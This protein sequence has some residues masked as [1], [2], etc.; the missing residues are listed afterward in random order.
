ME[1]KKRSHA[2]TKFFLILSRNSKLKQK[3][4]KEGR[5]KNQKGFEICFIFSI[6]LPIVSNIDK[7]PL[8]LMVGI[9]TAK[10]T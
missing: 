8:V 1:T 2:C 3:E 4:L 7:L 9:I 6:C 5:R 10:L